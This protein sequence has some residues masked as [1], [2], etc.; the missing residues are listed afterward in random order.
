MNKPSLII[1]YG[2]DNREQLVKNVVRVSKDFF[3]RIFI[4]NSGPSFFVDGI[5]AEF[6]WVEVYNMP[7]FY[8]DLEP[9]R[10]VIIKTIPEN[11][12]FL[13]LDSDECPSYPLLTHLQDYLEIFEKEGKNAI[14]MPWMEHVIN[15]EGELYHRGDGVYNYVKTWEEACV[16]GYFAS[17]RLLKNIPG[18]EIR[19]NYGMHEE[20]IIGSNESMGYIGFPIIHRKSTRQYVQS[21]LLSSWSMPSVHVNPDKQHE[22]LNCP[23]MKMLNELKQK[24]GVK[25]SN[26]FV[27]RVS[28]EKDEEFKRQ[29]E[30]F[31]LA[32]KESKQ[33]PFMHFKDILQF[34]FDLTT[35]N[36]F[37]G[38]ECCKFGEVQI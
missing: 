31:A 14:R 38:K 9:C 11:E 34:N 6:P 23:E 28:I 24:T 3:S 1:Q 30:E 18:W 15:K 20:F 35:Q 12:W 2:C 32:V 37:C 33:F 21:V 17:K 19:T 22:L 26:D 13:H 5:K 4:V 29:F 27:I 7:Y 36:H 16:C 8:G 25:T 10:R